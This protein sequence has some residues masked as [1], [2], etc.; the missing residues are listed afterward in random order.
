MPGPLWGAVGRRRLASPSLPP[1]VSPAQ[2]A[3]GLF[4]AGLNKGK[5]MENKKFEGQIVGVLWP[6][7]DG[8]PGLAGGVQSEVCDLVIPAGARLLVSKIA[9]PTEKG[10]KYRLI[11]FPANK[12]EGDSGAGGA[13]DSYGDPLPF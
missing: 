1:G 13:G 8:K 7:K 6:L 11:V 4:T 12:P 9:D 2:H 5:H 3:R 10:P